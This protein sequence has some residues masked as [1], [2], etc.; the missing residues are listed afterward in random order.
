MTTSTKR[1]G[2]C[3]MGMAA[4]SA[5]LLV[6][7]AAVALNPAG[8]APGGRSTGS[9]TICHR[10]NSVDNPYRLIEVA[11]DS[12]NG[13]LVGPDH[14]GH[15]GPV[16]DFSADPEAED[17]PYAPP[18]NEDDWGDIVPGYEWDGGSYPGLNWP[19][20]QAIWENGCTAPA[21]DPQG[22]DPQ[23]E[24][25]QG[26]DPVEDPEGEDPQGEDPE[27]EDPV[28]DPEGED[29]QGEDPVEDPEGEDPQGEDPQGED[30]QG[31]DPESNEVPGTPETPEVPETPETPEVSEGTPSAGSEVSSTSVEKQPVVVLGVQVV[32]SAE[33]P[34]TGQDTVPL[35]AFGFGL[36]LLGA[37]AVMVSRQEAAQ[38]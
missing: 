8:A 28:E 6:G 3:K 16:F 2:V 31:E 15:A 29:P 21:A 23:G 35:A 4:V 33:L 13:E 10:T 1:S 7:V 22:E 32:R 9:V 19:E 12:T 30:P 26:E 11:F 25:P 18:L 38:V 36:I 24:D 5:G 14:T 27:G 20:G 17:Y 37:G 34:R